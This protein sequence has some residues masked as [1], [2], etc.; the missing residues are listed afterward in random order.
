VRLGADRVEERPV[1][2]LQRDPALGERIGELRRA[3]KRRGSAQ[4]RAA[5]RDGE[6]DAAYASDPLNVAS[7]PPWIRR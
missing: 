5:G 6:G 7:V 2:A 4:Q 1:V 3:G